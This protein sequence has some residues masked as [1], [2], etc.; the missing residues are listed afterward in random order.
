MN[1]C[2]CPDSLPWCSSFSCSLALSSGPIVQK[3]RSTL[4]K[5]VVRLWMT[6][7]PNQPFYQSRSKNKAVS[8]TW[9]RGRAGAFANLCTVAASKA[10]P[11]GHPPSQ[12]LL[13]QG[14]GADAPICLC[15]G[16]PNR[17]GFAL[18]PPGGDYLLLD[19]LNNFLF[20]KC[21][22]PQDGSGSLDL[23]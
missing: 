2:P 13:L 9:L 17:Q 12:S 7:I 16:I 22:G 21:P 15:A 20:C 10:V 19:I 14:T 23:S 11:V 1:G 5:R 8:I 18:H 3:T 6:M 4:K